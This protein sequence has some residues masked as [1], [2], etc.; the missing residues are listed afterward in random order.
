LIS[1][2]QQLKT[3]SKNVIVK[4]DKAKGVLSHNAEILNEKADIF[5][6]DGN[7]KLASSLW[8]YLLKFDPENQEIKNKLARSERVIKNMRDLR[9]KGH[10]VSPTQ[11]SPGDHK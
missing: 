4:I 7:I 9:D 2:L 10:Q 3:L 1:Q 5:Y 8:E 11:T 6:R